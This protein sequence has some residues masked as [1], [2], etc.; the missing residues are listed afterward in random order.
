LRLADRTDNL[1]H[2][3]GVEILLPLRLKHEGPHLRLF[4]LGTHHGQQTSCGARPIELQQYG[5]WE[6]NNDTRRSGAGLDPE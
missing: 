2:Q 1:N 6:V 5:V 3:D 4:R